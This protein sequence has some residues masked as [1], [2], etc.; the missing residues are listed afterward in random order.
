MQG[1]RSGRDSFTDAPRLPRPRGG[2]ADR[3][4]WLFLI[5]GALLVALGAFALVQSSES[6]TT[7]A[8]IAGVTFIADALSLS[9][10]AAAAEETRGFYLL[11]GLAGIAGIAV[12]IFFEGQE[13]FRLALVL[14][15]YLIV[16]GFVDALVAWGEITDFTNSSR[17]LW[18]RTLLAAGI[19]SVALGLWALISRGDSTSALLLIVSGQALTR[20]MAMITASSRLRFL[21]YE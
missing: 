19:V 18:A 8:T 20:G 7:L 12:L 15:A 1:D 17:S 9:V 16:R 21:A 11:G 10:L 14:A 6:I 2:L 13:P 4:W 3:V 5:C